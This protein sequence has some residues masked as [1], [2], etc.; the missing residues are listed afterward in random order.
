MILI[1]G[2]NLL[3]N[4]N[5]PVDKLIA[6]VYDKKLHLSD[7]AGMFPLNANHDDSLQLIG[8]FATR[9]TKEQFFNGSRKTY[10]PGF[11]N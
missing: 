4:K 5:K 8:S 1:Q 11:G 9:W 3:D 2:C 7:M 6:T 10:S